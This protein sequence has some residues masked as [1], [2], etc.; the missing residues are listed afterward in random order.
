MQ[1]WI[2]IQTAADVIVIFGLRVCTMSRQGLALTLTQ[3]KERKLKRKVSKRRQLEV[4]N[5]DARVA[6]SKR[7]QSI[8]RAS[9]SRDRKLVAKGGAVDEMFLIGPDLAKNA[10]VAWPDVD[11]FDEHDPYANQERS[12]F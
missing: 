7:L 6:S 10:K 11:L 3:M 2:G 5:S 8:K 9:Q 12:K 1:Y 4:S